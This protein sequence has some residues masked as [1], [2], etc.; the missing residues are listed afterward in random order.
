MTIATSALVLL[1]VVLQRF[2]GYTLLEN[3]LTRAPAA[4]TDSHAGFYTAPQSILELHRAPDGK[5]LRGYLRSGD[6]IAAL[7]PVRFTTARSV[8]RPRTTTAREQS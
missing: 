5:T 3:A 6:R 4:Q 1:L 7:A 2:P 8:R